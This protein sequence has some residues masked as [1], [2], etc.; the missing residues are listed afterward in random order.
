[1]NFTSPECNRAVDNCVSIC[2]VTKL[3]IIDDILGVISMEE[4]MYV[5]CERR[6]TKKKTQQKL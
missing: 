1:M 5:C 6:K 4:C 3:A 2:M